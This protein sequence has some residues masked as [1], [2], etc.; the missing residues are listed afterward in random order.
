MLQPP[1]S[2]RLQ[3]DLYAGGS[4]C[5]ALPPHA[6]THTA[7]TALRASRRESAECSGDLVVDACICIVGRFSVYFGEVEL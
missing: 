6:H 2:R 1:L 4:R 5:S 7:P 3:L